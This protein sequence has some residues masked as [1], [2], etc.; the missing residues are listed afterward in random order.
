MHQSCALCRGKWLSGRE[1][2]R[3]VIQRVESQGQKLAAFFCE[4]VLSCAGQVFLPDGYL[5]EVYE[6][7]RAHGALCIADEV[8]CGFGRLGEVFWGFE[9][10][11]CTLL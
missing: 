5:A 6:E 10:H 3:A 7:M 4:S 8:Q 1:S 9:L 11:V 2:A